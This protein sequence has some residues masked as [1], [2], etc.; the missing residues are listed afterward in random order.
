MLQRNRTA[1]NEPTPDDPLAET[2]LLSDDRICK[3]VPSS[4][5]PGR[6][7]DTT[8]VSA[9]PQTLKTI[10]TRGR[11]MRSGKDSEH[12]FAHAE[13]AAVIATDTDVAQWRRQAIEKM[14]P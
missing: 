12:G 4:K 11:N 1:T 7:G 9:A 2:R 5:V 8:A 10:A 13:S 14:V 3:S 6:R